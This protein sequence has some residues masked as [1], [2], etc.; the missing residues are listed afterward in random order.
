MK[1]VEQLLD[2]MYT[3]PNAVIRFCA[4]DIFL[5]LHSYA[6]YLS[7]ACVRSQAGG[8]FFLG[9]FSHRLLFS[10]RFQEW[11]QF[12]IFSSIW[13]LS[14]AFDCL[15]FTPSQLS[16]IFG[17]LK[18]L[19][20]AFPASISNLNALLNAHHMDFSLSLSSHN[21]TNH[22]VSARLLGEQSH[23]HVNIQGVSES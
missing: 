10:G 19:S 6:I 20:D 11:W 2:Y 14:F 23:W 12:F 1:R 15:T 22:T 8:Y 17:W 9:R 18:R 21:P 4:S 16:S 3:N 5:N 13:L 7:A